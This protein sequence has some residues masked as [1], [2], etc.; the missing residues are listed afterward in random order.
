MLSGK[1][2]VGDIAHQI[3]FLNYLADGSDL[4]TKTDANMIA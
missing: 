1:M 2:Q 3:R 4:L